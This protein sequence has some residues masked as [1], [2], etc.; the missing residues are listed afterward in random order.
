MRA[1]ALSC[2]LLLI[3]PPVFAQQMD[4]P[5]VNWTVPPYRATSGGGITTMVDATPP[6]VF[7]GLQP[8]RLLDTRNNLNPLGGGGPFTTNQIR[9]YTLPGNCGIPSGTDAVSLN[10]TATETVANPFGHLKVWPVGQAEPNV[11]T[12]NWTAAGQTVA[13]AAIVPLGA[14]GAINVK[15]GN[16][17]SQVI[18]DV[19]GYFSDSLGNPANYLFLTNDNPGFATAFFYNLASVNNSS[20]VFGFVGPSFLR[21][22][23]SAAGVRGDGVTNG[24]AGISQQLAVA[25]SL[26]DEIG[27]EKAFGILGFQEPSRRAGAHGSLNDL[28]TIG[29]LGVLDGFDKIGVVGESRTPGGAGVFGVIGRVRDSS[30]STLLSGFLGWSQM[31]AQYGVYSSGN[32]HVQ[33]TFTASNNKGFVQPH[34]YDASKEIRYISLEGPHTEVYFRGTAQVSQG[35]TRISI[36]EHFRFVA[37]A[38]TY[39][40]LVTPVGDMATVAVVAEGPDG[41]VVRASRNVKI[42]YVVFAEREAVRNPDPVIENVHF[43]PDT[44]ID[45]LAHLPDSYRQLM[46]QNGTLNADG[47]VNMET[48]RRLG[49]DRIWEERPRPAPQPSSP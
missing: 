19:N 47:T 35:V 41:I 46:I 9:T 6:R 33:G 11:S 29:S 25:G 42:H 10:M 4:I 36:P 1:P 23:Y 7:I 2:V 31:S 8:C 15:S 45:F 13:N 24:V 3:S 44:N 32:S 43:R 27:A 22:N 28:S 5:L 17:G 39:S 40:T 30:G 20:G 16:A 49:W 48:A 38:R 37:D 18:I 12:L 26:V 14:G 34:P 21:P